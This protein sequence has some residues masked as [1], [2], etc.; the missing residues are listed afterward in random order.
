[1]T[2]Q[3]L[4]TFN[5]VMQYYSR[6]K[7]EKVGHINSGMQQAKTLSLERDLNCITRCENPRNVVFMPCLHIVICV[8]CS[9]PQFVRCP[10]C[11][12]DN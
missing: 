11:R 1:M 2:K 9:G 3:F 12:R 7:I 6:P 8:A 10:I 4:K 5:F